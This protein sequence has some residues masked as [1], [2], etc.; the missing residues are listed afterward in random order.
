[1]TLKQVNAMLIQGGNY[2]TETGRG[3][4]GKLLCVC[5]C[6]CVCV[7]ACVC[8]CVRVCVRKCACVCACVC[9]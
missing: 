2:C 7:C 3:I 6:V 4:G 5:V 8:V 9:A 1:M